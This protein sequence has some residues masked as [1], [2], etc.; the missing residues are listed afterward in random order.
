MQKFLE[1][2]PNSSKRL[3]AFPHSPL[4]GKFIFVEALRLLYRNIDEV[5]LSIDSFC[6][7]IVWRHNV[8]DIKSGK[9]SPC[10]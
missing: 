1:L 7:V 3:E 10:D 8:L 4:F 5:R 6:D 9:V 2:H